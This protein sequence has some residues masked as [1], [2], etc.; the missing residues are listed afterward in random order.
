MHPFGGGDSMVWRSDH[1]AQNPTSVPDS[2]Q[3]QYDRFVNKIDT[4]TLEQIPNVIV[5]TIFIV[6]VTFCL[7]LGYPYTS[8]SLCILAYVFHG[9][10]VG[11]MYSLRLTNYQTW[12]S[13]ICNVSP[14]QITCCCWRK[15]CCLKCSCVP[16]GS[17]VGSYSQGQSITKIWV[18]EVEPVGFSPWATDYSAHE[19]F[20]F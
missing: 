9:W 15:V 1:D 10:R 20:F 5:E 2:D 3:N 17:I 14:V 19:M 8:L 13:F 18:S 7:F 4:L 16:Q 11:C 6:F 12:L